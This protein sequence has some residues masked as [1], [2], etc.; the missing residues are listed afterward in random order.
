MAKIVSCLI[1]HVDFDRGKEIRAEFSFSF[2][3]K[4][5]LTVYNIKKHL[6]NEISDFRVK[7][8]NFMTKLNSK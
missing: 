8:L 4:T 5:I 6:E 1:S 2:L 3:L 7:N